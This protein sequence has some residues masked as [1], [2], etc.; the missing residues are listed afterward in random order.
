MNPT[1]DAVRLAAV[2]AA[3]AVLGVYEAVRPDDDRPW[4]AILAARYYAVGAATAEELAAAWTEARAAAYETPPGPARYA[5]RAAMWTCNP[6]PGNAASVARMYAY[7]ATHPDAPADAQQL[8]AAAADVDR[9]GRA[10]SGM[11]AASEARA[12]QDRR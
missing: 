5:A 9:Y 4:Q 10:I 8:A 7:L 2:S 6:A 12:A 1:Y 3:I 11:I